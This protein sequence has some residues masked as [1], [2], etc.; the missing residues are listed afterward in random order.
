MA[1][2][3]ST[4][5]KSNTVASISGT[6]FNS[7]GTP[8]VAGDVGRFIRLAGGAGLGSIRR[9]TAYVNTSRV[10]VDFVWTPG[11]FNSIGVVE[12]APSA[13][14]TWVMSY[15]LA[16]LVNGTDIILSNGMYYHPGSTNV[17]TLANNVFVADINTTISFDS[18]YISVNSLACW[19]WGY[20]T[21]GGVTNLGCNITDRASAVSGGWSPGGGGGDVQFHRC[22]IQCNA[23]TGGFW[24]MYRGNSGCYHFI[25]CV[26]DGQFGLRIQGDKSICLNATMTG[27]SHGVSP[28]NAINPIA[29][30]RGVTTYA[31][32]QAVYENYNWV[33]AIAASVRAPI[34]VTYVYA[35]CS[36]STGQ[37]GTNYI[38]DYIESEVLSA[39]NPINVTNEGSASAYLS[40]RQ[41]IDTRIVD[42]SL[43]TISDYARRVIRN[44]AGTAV[45][46]TTSNTSSFARYVATIKTFLLNSGG[47]KAWAIGTAYGPYEEGVCCYGYQPVTMPLPLATSSNLTL[48]LLDDLNITEPVRST[49]Q[50]YTSLANLDQF[51]DSYKSWLVTNFATPWPTFGAQKVNGSGTTLDCGDANVVVDGTAAAAF[52][53]NTGTNTITIKASIL[54]AGTKFAKLVTNG[55]IS[56][57]NGATAGPALVYADAT[58]T[59]VP[60]VVGGIRSGTKCRLVRT[61][62]EAELAIGTAG[63]SGFVTRTAW[64]TDLPIRAD[65]TYTSGL[66]CE[67]EASALGTL[68]ANGA[69]LTV[70]QEPCTV[71]ETNGLVGADVTG[72]VL[73]A[74]NVEADADEF[75]NRM[76]VQEFY[77][78][79]KYT[80]M[81][82]AGIRT[83]F[84]AITAENA[85][86]Y[87]VN[88]SKCPL[89]IDQKDLVNTLLFTGG[90]IYRDDG[91]SIRLAGSGSIEMIPT[92]VF[93]SPEAEQALT[94]IRN[95]IE[96][97]E[98]HTAAT[99]QKRQ[100]GTATVLLEKVWTGKPLKDFA[101]VQP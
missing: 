73:D 51:Y 54:Y 90:L 14:D 12:T 29:V 21:S 56:F 58:A 31:G 9:I 52:A 67:Q 78:W 45:D 55:T 23:A 93:E 28:V 74:P 30:C 5:Y 18:N 42:A 40:F 85:H 35:T 76:A 20:Y 41:W 3:V 50:A 64:T 70:V 59:S 16:D 17:I 19:M 63:A 81:S 77:A 7:N 47:N 48:T 101:A 43:A 44:G 32:L 69:L 86:K 2:T 89:K 91:E 22:R 37:N 24:R 46:N 97:D 39:P 79:Y 36:V 98:V 84:G 27:N 95:L 87:R 60:I 80:L 53:A 11:P 15:S 66:D 26:T 88:A 10:I 6:T 99:I 34:G 57:V 4:P 49:V 62:T 25:D 13:G 68:T 82:D 72:L 61:D 92:D 65:S 33:G 100:R 8:F 83:L 96:A 38:D 71:Y 75:D 1:L 94:A